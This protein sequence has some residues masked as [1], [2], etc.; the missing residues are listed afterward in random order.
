[1]SEPPTDLSTAQDEPGVLLGTLLI[2]LL[3]GLLGAVLWVELPTPTARGFVGQG[4]VL[5]GAYLIVWGLIFLASCFYGHK[6]FFLRWLFKT[7]AAG[8]PSRAKFRAI[9]FFAVFT[10]CGIAA[11]LVG[12]GLL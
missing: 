8:R 7:G 4:T 10:C 9:F 3:A 1:M 11:V 6:T 5:V 12:T 2:A